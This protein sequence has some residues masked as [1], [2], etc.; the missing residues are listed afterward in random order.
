MGDFCKVI[1]RRPMCLKFPLLE[2]KLQES[3]PA[4]HSLAT[5]NAIKHP[6]VRKEKRVTVFTLSDI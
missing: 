1:K 4:L 2:N 3:E 5:D 6:T